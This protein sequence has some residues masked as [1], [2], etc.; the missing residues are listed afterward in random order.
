MFGDNFATKHNVTH[1]KDD[2]NLGA[3]ARYGLFY[4]AAGSRNPG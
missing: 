4:N 3:F 2:A 1:F